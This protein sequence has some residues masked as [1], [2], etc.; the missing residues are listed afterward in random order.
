MG[1]ERAEELARL[2]TEMDQNNTFITH[3]IVA[4]IM[5]QKWRIQNEKTQAIYQNRRSPKIEIEMLLPKRVRTKF[6]QLWSFYGVELR[7]F[8][9]KIELDENATYPNGC[10]VDENITHVLCECVSPSDARQRFWKGP[11]TPATMTSHP[12]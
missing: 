12:Y 7:Y 1:N 10:R 4:K 11:V 2:G 3:K 8:R 9:K 5:N 6:A